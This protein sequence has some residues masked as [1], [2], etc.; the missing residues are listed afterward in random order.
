MPLR[1]NTISGLFLDFGDLNMVIATPIEVSAPSI[2][3]PHP[4]T[5][6]V[7]SS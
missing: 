3:A 5:I 2:R 7:D 1:Y 6:L 4:T